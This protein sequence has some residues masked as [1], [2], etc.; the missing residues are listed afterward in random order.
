M[1]DNRERNLVSLNTTMPN[2]MKEAGR[3]RKSIFSNRTI[4]KG[5][6]NSYKGAGTNS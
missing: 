4:L 1:I 5:S 3:D 2:T 6:L